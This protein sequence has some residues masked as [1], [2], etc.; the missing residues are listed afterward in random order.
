MSYSTTH[1]TFFLF[2]APS[3]FQKFFLVT[4]YIQRIP[5]S[6]RKKGS[7][8]SLDKRTGVQ[9]DPGRT[10]VRS[11]NCSAQNPA[12]APGSLAQC[13]VPPPLILHTRAHVFRACTRTHT[14]TD[15]D[16]MVWTQTGSPLLAHRVFPFPL[17]RKPFGQT[18][19]RLPASQEAWFLTL[20]ETWFLILF[21]SINH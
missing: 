19:T 10:H 20:L 13:T 21:N 12:T 17:P 2:S 15:T 1:V 6:Q 3:I 7:C 4:D 5:A 14:H 9:S 11:C 18:D 8:S 16:T